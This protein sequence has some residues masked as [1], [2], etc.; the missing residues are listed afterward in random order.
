VTLETF[1]S[2]AEVI[3]P[4]VGEGNLP[5][6]YIPPLLQLWNQKAK[7][8]PMDRTLLP[9][10]E[11]LA[12]ISM[13]IGMNYQ[14]WS[15]QTFD[16]A[17]SMINSAL[18]ILSVNDFTDEEADSMVCAVDV[19]DGLVEGLESN[20]AELVST[21]TH[22]DHFL[23]LLNTTVSHDVE[24]VRMSAFA[25]MGDL[26]IHCPALLQDGLSD[27]I[28]E[29][30]LCIDP[31][32]PSVCNNA[33][34]AVGEVL[35]KCVG[36]HTVIQ[37]FASEIVQNLIS[38]IM[39]SK[40]NDDENVPMSGLIENASTTMGRL[41][42]VNPMFVAADL[43]RFLPAWAEGCAKINE[44]TERRDAFEGL[45]MAV[46]A[47]PNSIIQAGPDLAETISVFLLAIMSWHIP[48][49]KISTQLLSGNYS[50]TPFPQDYTDLQHHLQAFANQF[51][52]VHLEAW[53]QVTNGL[54]TNVRRLFQ[55]QYN[56]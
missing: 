48:P 23:T 34:W 25:L 7:A 9:L 22:K 20:F 3:G 42:K 51:L 43:P 47:N 12:L 2:L 46:Q 17:M 18:M 31:S 4:A 11:S 30:I 32:F 54:P 10:M 49:G 19:L 41:S 50:F 5:N 39:G 55:E 38:L 40:Y 15:L 1:G 37:P 35:V 8:N 13:T 44:N 21:S 29:A 6:I 16:M 28:T 53:S 36:N 27:L 33:V 45:L 24:A 56:L 52:K 14:P 26:A